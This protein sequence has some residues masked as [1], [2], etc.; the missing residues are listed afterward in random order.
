MLARAFQRYLG[1]DLSTVAGR[2]LIEERY[3]SL[4]QQVPIIYL[5]GL[6]NLSAM[7]IAAD[8]SLSLGFNLPTFILLCALLRLRSWFG[9]GSET[10]SHEL[11][12]RR[13]TPDC[14]FRSRRLP[15]G[16][17]CAASTSSSV[18]DTASHMAVILFGG[19]TAIGVAYGLTALPAA[20]RIPLVLIIGPISLV[21][22][23]SN[24][25]EFVGAAFG[26]VVVAG[27]TVQ[28]LSA[29]SKHFTSVVRSRSNIA[30]EQKRAERAHQEAMIAATTDF[31][32]GLPNRRAFV[33]R[34]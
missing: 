24:E 30:C 8:R 28:L 17:C 6:V 2:A 14:V 12:V 32:T 9:E 18:G 34:A 22:A 25:R 4:R 21:A 16:V 7:E 13:M 31:L 10:A 5:L 20:G 23:Y 29:H 3:W 11:M 26:L 19:L 33:C 27:L 15:R 1:V